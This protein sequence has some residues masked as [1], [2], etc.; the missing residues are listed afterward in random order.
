MY[1]DKNTTGSN[2]SFIC[3]GKKNQ[4][5]NSKDCSNKLIRKYFFTQL[6]LLFIKKETIRCEGIAHN[7]L[8]LFLQVAWSVKCHIKSK[9]K[10]SSP[11]KK[12]NKPNKPFK[13]VCT[14]PFFIKPNPI[15]KIS[16]KPKI[17]SGVKIG[18]LIVVLGSG[19]KF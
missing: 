17:I 1:I 12:K 10:P 8:K 15:I 16:T 3:W 7:K 2:A 19:Y 4:L 5:S 18:L 9:I 11:N 13:A 6:F 14:N